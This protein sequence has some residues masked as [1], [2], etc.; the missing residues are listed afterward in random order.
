VFNELHAQAALRQHYQRLADAE[1][2][3]RHRVERARR[4]RI[5]IGRRVGSE[6][7]LIAVAIARGS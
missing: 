4:V 7:V 2:A 6:R 5:I 1:R 3:N